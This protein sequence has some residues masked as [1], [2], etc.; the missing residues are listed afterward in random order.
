VIIYSIHSL[1]VGYNKYA[2]P[3][4]VARF[5]GMRYTIRTETII[6]IGI[7]KALLYYK[8]AQLWKGFQSAL[9]IKYFISRAETRGCTMEYHLRGVTEKDKEFIY[10]IK[11]ESNL[12]YVQQ[13]WGWD[14]QYQ[15]RDFEAAFDPKAMRIIVCDGSDAGFIQTDESPATIN[16]TEIHIS[17]Q[18][19]RCG[20]G[21]DIIRNIIRRA[22]SEGKSVTIGCFIQNADAK[23]LYERLG[24]KT[25]AQTDTHYML[26]YHPASGEPL[27]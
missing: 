14:D 25:M 1:V 17:P 9:N 22:V 12:G 7:P 21:S 6:K 16:I 24:F 26:Q 15:T 4:K 23:K 11:K 19:R 27:S 10:R 20:I 8:Y 5:G 3:W 2:S 13:I 18:Y